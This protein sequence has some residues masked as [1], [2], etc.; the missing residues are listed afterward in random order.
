MS[1]ISEESYLALRNRL[2]EVQKE[3]EIA[4]KREFD[5]VVMS[6]RRVISEYGITQRDIFGRTK[7]DGNRDNR[8]GRVV[9][10]YRHPETG[11]TWT[12]R[13]RPPRWIAGKEYAQFLI[14]PGE[15]AS[16][17]V[18]HASAGTEMPR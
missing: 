18:V 2:S 1:E 12:G 11:E 10:K 4:R 9:V 13:G 6:V 3:I 5:A 16:R 7:L 17:P 14:Q 15:S 8:F